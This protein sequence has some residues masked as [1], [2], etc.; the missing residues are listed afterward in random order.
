MTSTGDNSSPRTLL[1]AVPN[2]TANATN[3]RGKMSRRQ[4]AA[5]A[6]KISVIAVI[7]SRNRAA[8]DGGSSARC[9]SL[10]T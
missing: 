10:K 9:H 4:Q 7:M 1:A 3:R 8:E 2:S 5:A 6:S